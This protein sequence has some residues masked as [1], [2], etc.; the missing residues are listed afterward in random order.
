MLVP[1]LELPS[2][3][4]RPTLTPPNG[5]YIEPAFRLALKL[6]TLFARP[7]PPPTRSGPAENEAMPPHVCAR[8]A[9]GTATKTP[10]SASPKNRRMLSPGCGFK[11]DGGV[12]VRII[13]HDEPSRE[14][15][16]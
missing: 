16:S 14:H 15:K 2:T 5:P 7:T 8:T 4:E 9:A 6:V 10:T 11:P 12:I 1:L 13:T 3:S